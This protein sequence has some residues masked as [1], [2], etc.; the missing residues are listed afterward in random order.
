MDGN[1]YAGDLLRACAQ[2]ELV[3]EERG[4]GRAGEEAKMWFQLTPSL[5]QI[6]QKLPE[7]EWPH[8]VHRLEAR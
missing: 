6:P 2:K 3:M 8:R 7:H 5:S 1:S 4:Q